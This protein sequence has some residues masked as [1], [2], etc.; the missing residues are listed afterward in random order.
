M[1]FLNHICSKRLLITAI[2][3]ILILSACSKTPEPT[4]FTTY[5]ST[6]T[7]VVT[8]EPNSK[9]E[10]GSTPMNVGGVQGKG[11]PT[12][13][14]AC[15]IN[16]EGYCIFTGTP[17]KNGL[18]PGTNEI[19]DNE[20]TFLFIV[21]ES[22]AANSSGK[23]L[24]PKG[25]P[26]FDGDK[27]IRIS[28]VN[29]TEDEKAFHKAM[30][31]MFPIRNALMYDIK[32][33]SQNKWQ[34]LVKEL[35]VRQIKDITYLGGP[36][37]KD[38]YYGRDGIFGLAKNPN[39]RDIHHDVMKFLEESGLYLLCHVTSGEFSQMLRE[40][41]PEG[42]DPCN[43]AG[44][45]KKVP[46]GSLTEQPVLQNFSINNLGPYDPVNTTFGDLKFDSRFGNRVFNEFGM[47]RL[48]GHGNEHYNPTFEFRAP[49][50]TKVISPIT[51]V[52]SYAEWQSS[53][54][55]WEIHIRPTAQ[56]EWGFGIDHIVSIDCIRPEDPA[57]TCNL[58]LVVGGKIVS[59]GT[60]VNEGEVLGYI[61]N[62]SD[63]E[64]I[65]IGGRTELTV[66][67][68]LDDYSGT[69]NYCPTLYI[70][71]T[72]LGNKI[73]DLMGSYEEWSGNLN[74]YNQKE[75]PSPGCLYKAIKQTGEK[76]EPIKE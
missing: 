19:V 73:S 63:P 39:G 68:Y 76:T 18:R 35:R 56:S 61:G 69:I 45:S 38:N 51:G 25:T 54:N 5:E 2:A 58:P 12:D 28:Q 20:G 14:Y 67:K 37:P 72:S 16:A 29:M 34:K 41:H 53:Q 50:T 42:H 62:W 59:E 49:A 9:P 15:N 57:N 13:Q 75:M 33:I 44:I 22:A 74:I 31:I 24:N 4:S 30:A 70:S 71:E 32:E 64:N 17:H 11:R 23:I 8:I 60:T 10:V 66:F 27:L 7:S 21:D 40:S 55:D 1:S 46:F 6:P 48:D 52:I 36:T 65:G 26:A 47:M 43:D 3:L